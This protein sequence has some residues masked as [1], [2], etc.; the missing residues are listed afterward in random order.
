MKPVRG[1]SRLTQLA[2]LL[3]FA[4][5]VAAAE[6]DWSAY[7][8]VLHAHVRAG[9][10]QGV[11][12]NVVD[13][14]ALRRDPQ[15]T[16]A[17]RQVAEMAPADIRTPATRLAFYL[18]AYNLLAL[19]LVADHWPLESIRDIGNFLRPVWKRPAGTVAGQPMTLAT[20]EHEILRKMGDPRIHFA[21]VCASVSCP[22][23]RAEPYQAS[24]VARQLDEQVTNFLSND[25][26]GLVIEGERVRVSKIFDWFEE[27]F[28]ARGGV[29][30]FIQ[31]YRELPVAREIDASLPY[32][33]EVNA[34]A[35]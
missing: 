15:F 7:A 12:L 25:A 4:Q 14:A 16:L 34:A 26:K 35:N 27:D 3:I 20:I 10:L 6:P 9:E 28:A 22:D 31:H 18:N 8:A 24:I 23:L 17:L 29:R 11:R 30:G 5:Q 32:R 2:L 13:Y 33:W 1:M 21:I 19:K